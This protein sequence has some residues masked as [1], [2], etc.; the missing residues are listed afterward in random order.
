MSPAFRNF[1]AKQPRSGSHTFFVTA[2]TSQ[3][4][5]LLQSERMANLFIDVLR[6]FVNDS[7]FKV[8]EFVVMRNFVQLLI[9]VYGENTIEQV[10]RHIKARFAFR[11]RAEFGIR[12][13]IWE[14][15]SK[16]VRVPDR[17]TFLKH[18][19]AI[20][21]QPIKAGMAESVEAYPY[22]SAYLRKQKAQA[23]AAGD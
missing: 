15:E 2:K 4:K 9:T 20:E 3:G 18:K 6:S 1:G 21:Q 5:A 19:A 7:R 23:K 12:G 8:N 11:V 17:S 14:F 10:L 13:W 16:T 22:S